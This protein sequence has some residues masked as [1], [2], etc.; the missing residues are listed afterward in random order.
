[1]AGRAERCLRCGN[2][3]GVSFFIK[4]K[5]KW[6]E[7][8]CKLQ[9][10]GVVTIL[11]GTLGP[12]ALGGT[13]ESYSEAGTP[14]KWQSLSF[15]CVGFVGKLHQG[16]VLLFL[17]CKLRGK[18][19]YSLLPNGWDGRAPGTNS[20]KGPGSFVITHRALCREP[21]P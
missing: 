11:P 15:E 19:S 8:H 16:G 6:I 12:R 18:I 3:I 14:A 21:V 7:T 17:N 10:R 2:G 5:K 13:S 4:R 1:M 20:G 9:C